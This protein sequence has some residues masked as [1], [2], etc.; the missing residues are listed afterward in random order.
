LW[1]DHAG[2]P[3]MVERFLRE[4]RAAATIGS[5]HIAHVADAGTTAEG[6]VFLAMELLPGRDLAAELGERTRFSVAEAV[7]LLR[8]VLAALTA[9]HRAG[10]VHRDLKPAN[11][12]LAPGPDG[13]PF[14]KLLDFGSSKIKG[15]AT[16]T[17]AGM[18]LGTPQ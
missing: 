4:A 5:P 3:V 11:V 14:V 12:F 9:A 2:D 10:I 6:I 13:A 1:P 7:E 16:L 15:A 8:Q 17:A 18:V